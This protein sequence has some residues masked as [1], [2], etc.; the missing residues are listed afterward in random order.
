MQK[1]EVIEFMKK[2]KAYYQTFSMEDYVVREWQ[3]K[4]KPYDATDVY[5]KLEQHLNGELKDQI[6][7]LHYIIRY[8]RTSAE[9]LRPAVDYQIDCNLCGRTMRLSQYERH[10]DKCSSICYLLDILR[11]QDR[12]I[13]Y[14]YLANISQEKFNQIY[15]RY[16]PKKVNL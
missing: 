15:E 16:K 12:S 2:I 9:K 1:L 7:K 4:L 3:E 10:Y 6:P 11:K 5:Q 14:Q 13:D 8:L